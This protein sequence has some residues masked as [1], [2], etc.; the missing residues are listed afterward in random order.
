M[1]FSGALTEAH[2]IDVVAERNGFTRKK[3]IDTFEILL[4]LIKQSL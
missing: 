1:L 2:I 3:S 4:E